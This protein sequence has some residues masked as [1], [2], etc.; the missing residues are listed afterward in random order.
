MSDFSIRPVDIFEVVMRQ[1]KI[2]LA[3]FVGTFAFFMLVFLVIPRS[4]QSDVTL[5]VGVNYFQNP[6]IGDLVSQTHDPGELRSEREKIIQSSL[7]V[8]FANRMGEKFNLFKTDRNDPARSVEV[9]WFIKSLNIS[10]VTSTQFKIIYKSRK[11]DIAH[12]VIQGAIASIR[13]YMYLNRI[14]MLEQ[15]LNVLQ[16]EIGNTA[17]DNSGRGS[18]LPATTAAKT[19]A[20][21]EQIRQQV[22]DLEKRLEDLR[23]TYS[24]QHPSIAAVRSQ[25]AEMKSYEK[26][27]SLSPHLTHR[28]VFQ[29]GGGTA[30]GLMTIK[31]DLNKQ[32]HLVNIS[33]EMEK[34]DPSMAAYMSLTKEP[35][36]PS[37]PVFPKFRLF[38]LFGLVAGVVVATLAAA[39]I[40]FWQRTAMPVSF[41]AKRLKTSHLGTLRLSSTTTNKT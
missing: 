32:R 25:L 28:Q 36:Y 34:K 13:E 3:G 37:K 21:K 8:D 30:L 26:L 35:V 23:R 2:I 22:G 1:K 12:G 17:N 29:K 18:S 39:L 16:N 41:I 27:G 6:L 19:D 33:L 15:L 7:G 38:V 9:E 24:E 10:A 4:Y 31:D 40:E 11:P 20:A 14:D 5:H